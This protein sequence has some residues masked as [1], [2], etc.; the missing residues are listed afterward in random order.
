MTN[1]DTAQSGALLLTR[2]DAQALFARHGFT[3]TP[4]PAPQGPRRRPRGIG[5]TADGRAAIELIGPEHTV[6]KI[7]LL[8]AR[9]ERDGESAATTLTDV[10]RIALPDWSA[11][12]AWLAGQSALVTG[13][14][15][16]ETRFGDCAI[17]LRVA[18]NGAKIAL[19]LTWQPAGAAPR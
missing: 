9:A 3:F 14:Q 18:E 8:V 10:A 2:A 7:T 12:A 19:T 17:M 13:R 4:D 15:P 11:G 1:E 6:F 5:E 16:A